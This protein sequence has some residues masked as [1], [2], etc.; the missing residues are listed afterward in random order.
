MIAT[1]N[2]LIDLCPE[3]NTLTCEEKTK[4]SKAISLK[5]FSK[6]EYVWRQGDSAKHVYIVVRGIV[7]F[8]GVT[9]KGTMTTN[10]FML[11]THIFGDVEVILE[12][13]RYCDAKALGKMLI[14]VIPKKLYLSLLDSNHSFCRFYLNSL[15]KW[16]FLEMR[17]R[18]Q[19]SSEVPG[20]RISYA[21]SMICTALL[22]TG[23][24]SKTDPI[25][26]PVSQ[27]IFASFARVSRQVTNKVFKSLSGEGILKTEYQKIV[28][29][30]PESLLEEIKPDFS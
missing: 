10:S 30:K 23:E 2:Q 22:E 4:L 27:E 15:A 25:E 26:L 28:I 24:Y 19:L 5:E 9:S 12:R 16:Y 29:L 1:H 20:L 17:Y 13:P 3:F 21:L 6:N 11:P 8:Y 14:A 7:L 18:S